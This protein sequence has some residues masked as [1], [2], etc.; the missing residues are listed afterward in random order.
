MELKTDIVIVGAGGGGAVLGL[1]L[2]RKGIGTVILEQAPGPP[3]GLRGEIVQ[4]NGQ[5]ILDELGLL[6]RL[7][8][9]AVRPV[10]A[11]HFCRVGGRRLCT[12]DYGVLPPPY[13]Q[14]LVTLPNVVH[15]VILGALEAAVPGCVRYGAE[16]KD[17]RREGNR[18]TG[19]RA[20][21][22]GEPLTVTA[23]VVVGADGAW[24]KLR[25]ALRIPASLHRYP[26]EY[27]ITILEG[28]DDLA[29]AR[30]FVGHRTILGVFPAAAGKAYIFSM[31]PTGSM[32]EL[33]A[34]GLEALR[35]RWRT[36]DPGLGR[37]LSNLNDWSQTACMPTGR[38]R[39]RTWITDG[40]VLIGD[41]A[42]AMNPH[43][44]QGR[45]Q[46]ML[47]AMALAELLPRCLE[48]GDCTATA[49]AAFERQRRPQVEMLQRLA[50]EQVLFWNTGNPILAALRDRVFRTLD[51]NPRLRYR[52][53]AVT[54]GVR[55]T[56][57]FGILDRFMAAGLL[58]DPRAQNTSD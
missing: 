42:H 39:A 57:P 44:S 20:E 10:R 16:F 49:L 35:E 58:P 1:A 2:A 29:E 51:R 52:T 15:H 33:R 31:I 47:D 43:A 28:A 45:M 21:Y 26:D 30:Y 22:R 53:L 11:F 7:P 41:A 55:Q 50:D 6:A 5:R 17:V 13:N 40:A 23:R 27:L 37:V 56:A 25:T 24:S 38:V 32:P 54:A 12:V 8:S 48:A 18:V 36:I 19:V 9:H 4:P 14:A 46:A 34:R 3:T